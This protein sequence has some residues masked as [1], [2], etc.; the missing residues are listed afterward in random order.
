MDFPL[1]EPVKAALHAAVERDDLGYV[2]RT[3]GLLEAF[4]GFAARRL[5][6]SV[7]PEQVALVTDVMVGIQELLLALTEPGDGV[8]LNPP[9]YPPYFREVPHVGRRA[10]RRW[11][12]RGVHGRRPS[13]AALQP[14]QPDRTRRWT[15]GAR[16]CRR[17]RRRARRVGDLR[18]DP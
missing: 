12:R 2:G 7:D 18:R 3:D 1:A 8:I 10:R 6:W 9:C 13:A 17:G 16:S 4:A 14:A 15:R 5:G 11:H